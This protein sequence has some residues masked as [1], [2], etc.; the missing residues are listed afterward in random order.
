MDEMLPRLSGGE[1]IVQFDDV[2]SF[3]LWAPSCL[4]VV[5]PLV[6]WS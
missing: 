3:S 2:L 6:L 4:S 1:L 5:S